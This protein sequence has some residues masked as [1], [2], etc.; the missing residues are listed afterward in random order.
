MSVDSSC[1]FLSS[2]TRIALMESK[3]A[4]AAGRENAGNIALCAVE[5]MGEV[6]LLL[7]TIPGAGATGS[8]ECRKSPGTG[9]R[10]D[11]AGAEAELGVRLSA[12]LSKVAV[13][14]GP[15][16]IRTRYPER[17]ATGSPYQAVILAVA[18]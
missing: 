15:F 14:R 8:T 6:A 11:A 3:F 12:I 5:G 10:G 9:K 16:E 1:D 2:A 4:P 13:S 17:A 7:V 18:G